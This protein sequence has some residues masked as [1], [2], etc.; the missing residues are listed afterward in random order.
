M[1]LKKNSHNSTQNLDLSNPKFYYSKKLKKGNG[2]VFA[3]AAIVSCKHKNI[4]IL[5][6]TVATSIFAV[7]HHAFNAP[8]IWINIDIVNLK[9][10]CVSRIYLLINTSTCKTG[11]QAGKPEYTPGW[12][13]SMRLRT[14]AGKFS[15]V[16]ALHGA[17]CVRYLGQ[18]MLLHA[19]CFGSIFMFVGFFYCSVFFFWFLN[20]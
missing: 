4:A 11:H 2:P 9:S 3:V 8:S 12:Q 7:W 19:G 6:N 17:H 1:C 14:P 16:V 10:M 13:Y 20:S 18:V 15:F 5:P